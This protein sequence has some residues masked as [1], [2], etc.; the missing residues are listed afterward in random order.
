MSAVREY[1][2]SQVDVFGAWG[3]PGNP[4]AVVHDA[5]DLTT[6]QMLRFASWTNLSETTF[7][8]RPTDPA[9]DYRVRI[10]TP[11]VELPFAGHPTL[12]SAHAWLRRGGTPAAPGVVAQECGV[13]VV[14]VRTADT[15]L[16]FA[17]PPLRRYEDVD[18]ATRERVLAALAVDPGRV[19]AMRWID[20]G[21]GWLGVLLD[22]ADTVLGLRPVAGALAGLA[23][24]VAG[25]HPGNDPAHVEIRAF[26]PDAG[27]LEDPVTGSANAGFARWLTDSGVVDG[28]YTARQGTALGRGGRI[29]V[30]PDAGEL[31]IGGTTVTV[32]DGTVGL[33]LG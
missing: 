8:C 7:L 23:V 31:W 13:G 28:A 30:T 25:Q 12:G 16:A 19:R 14:P 27:V 9:A 32:V 4:V 24:T 33:P 1:P 11:A 15:D 2:F 22:S 17:A 20:N 21:P 29:T 10:F 5:D 26:I 6:E 18:D 3:L